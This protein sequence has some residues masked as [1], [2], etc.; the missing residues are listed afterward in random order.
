[1]KL[2]DD[3]EVGLQKFNDFILD[4]SQDILVISGFSGTGKTTLVKECIASVPKLRKLSHLLNPDSKELS[5]DVILTA[6]TNQAA[7]ALQAATQRRTRTIHQLI[8][9]RVSPGFRNGKYQTSLQW[10][11][12][13]RTVENAII[14]I[15]EG[16]YIDEELLS[17]IRLG[18]RKCKLVIIGDPDQLLNVGS[19]RSPV[20]NAGYPTVHLAE[21]VRFKENGPIDSL[22]SSLRHTVQTGQWPSYNPDQQEVVVV[23]REEFE[24]RIIQEFSRPDRNASDA[25]VLAWRNAT[26]IKYNEAIAGYLTGNPKFQVGDKAVCNSPIF[27]PTG[28]QAYKN[29][30]VVT[31]TKSYRSS[32]RHGFHG[33]LISMDN[34]NLTVFMPDDYGDRAKAVALAEK[35]E[36]FRH[37]AYEVNHLWAD[38]RH[39]YASTVHKAQGSTYNKVF[40]DL[41]DLKH[42]P[43]SNQLARMLYVAVSRARYQVVLT[44]DLV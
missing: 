42:C 34:S 44:G 13:A 6:T 38:L 9:L 2:T 3:Q 23:G 36:S 21:P 19:D 25:V 37:L 27:D 14:V 32:P 41:E 17:Y 11:R 12:N 22:S 1:M 7:E 8:G 4:T 35:D 15:D 20:F 30:Q 18:T 24:Q 29:N 43:D 28:N 10:K 26:V 39:V 31:I 33:S 5:Y 40:I 16:S